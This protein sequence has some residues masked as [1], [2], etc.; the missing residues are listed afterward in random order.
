MSAG[1]VEFGLLSAWHA[2]REGALISND[3]VAGWVSQFPN[4]FA[5]LAAVDLAWPMV[6]VHKLRRAVGELGFVGIR[7]VPW[8]WDALPSQRPP[9]GHVRYELPHDF[10]QLGAGRPPGPGPVGDS[11]QPLPF[12]RATTGQPQVDLGKLWH[13]A[14]E[15]SPAHRAGCCCRD[16]GASA[17]AWVR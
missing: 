17:S 8:L 14:A 3:E 10:A 16:A 6:A 9:Q 7:V 15:Q 1:G 13:K 11:A 5:G 12:T 2:P 4:R